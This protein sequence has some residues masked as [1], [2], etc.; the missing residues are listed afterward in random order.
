MAKSR[1]TSSKFIPDRGPARYFH[2]RKKILRNFN[3]LLQYASE[4][5]WGTIFLI[6]GAPG[7]GKSALLHECEKLAESSGWKTSRIHA[8][9]LWDLDELRQSIDS[10]RKL[11]VEGGAAKVAIPGIAEAEVSAEL[12][13]QTVKGLLQKGKVPLLLILD[14]AQVL[15]TTNKPSGEHAKIASNVLDVVHNG[16]LG[17]PV[18]LIAGGLGTT[19][20]SF[21]ALGISR[22]AEDCFVEIGA[23]SKKSERAVIRDWLNK[24]GRAKGDPTAWIDAIANEAQGWPRH[25]Q[26]YSKRAADYLEA[27]DR[28]MTVNG[29]KAV[30][31]AGRKGRAV[32]YKQ[33]VDRFRGDQI[34]CLAMSMAGVPQGKPAEY[35][36]I[37]SLLVN[38]YGES[39]ANKLFDRFIE[40]GILEESG[41][42]YAVPIPS[43]HTWLTEE[44][45]SEK[46]EIPLDRQSKR[47]SITLNPGMDR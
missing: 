25:V 15:G 9:A 38:E 31:K 21:E 23:L 10:R 1:H 6:Q 32:Y 18:V 20:K 8:P 14:E 16:T 19:L 37:M 7:A 44:Y 28:L 3:E 35:K 5:T 34:R 4:K 30:L 24:E 39:K 43:M 22:F 46:I 41:I 26:S 40:K 27:R 2:G 29:L 36:D 17:R 11:N 12:P 33:R 45:A 47:I 13:P 42:G